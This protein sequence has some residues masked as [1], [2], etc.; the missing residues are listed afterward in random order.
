MHVIRDQNLCV[1]ECHLKRTLKQITD[2]RLS[3]HKKVKQL[4]LKITQLQIVDECMRADNKTFA[5]VE[6]LRKYILQNYDIDPF[7]ASTLYRVMK[8]LGFKHKKLTPRINETRQVKR[9]QIYFYRHLL[10][11]LQRP[12]IE[13]YYFDWT[14]FSDS[15][16]KQKGWSRAGEKAVT[17]SR[18][19]YSRLHLLAIINKSG[20]Y[21]FQVIR[22]TLTR[23]SSLT[24]FMKHF[25]VR[26][27]VQDDK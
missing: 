16:F 23:E 2:G 5:S 9:S 14:S 17:K 3:E 22:G 27:L 25:F 19:V 18:Y 26:L 20:V 24:S 11:A 6:E 4:L 13:L 8:L 12:N 21:S 1:P 10:G 15:N 7:S